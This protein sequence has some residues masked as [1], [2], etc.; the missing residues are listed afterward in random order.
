MHTLSSIIRCKFLLKLAALLI[1][2]SASLTA[3]PKRYYEDQ[4]A[5]TL[6]EMRASLDDL[7]HEINNHETEIKTF[8][9]KVQS[10]ETIIDSLRQNSS[11]VVQAHKEALKDS[12]ATLEMKINSLETT[13]KG[14][15]ADLK[16]FKNHANETAS[17][18]SQYKQKLSELE[19][20]LEIQ[21]DN[22]GSLQSAIK[23][24]TDA[25]QVKSNFQTS[26]GEK[27]YRVASGDSLEKI[28]RKHQT[29][30][31][32]LKE[33]NGLNNDKII[34]GQILKMP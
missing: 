8:D 17:A 32:V 25:L 33:L 6:R 20:I 5:T 14:L 18:L 30:I 10:L 28:A 23:S 21:N 11:E 4:T 26:S 24:I 29:T 34:V 31:Q 19:K 7:R 3:A 13:T 2:V 16:Q 1:L 15:V 22:L 27:T 9:E 12:S